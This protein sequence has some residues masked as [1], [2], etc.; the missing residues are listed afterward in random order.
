MSKQYMTQQ[1]ML[2]HL[3]VKRTAIMPLPPVLA[4]SSMQTQ[5]IRAFGI[6]AL[7]PK[8]TIAQKNSQ[9]KEM[10]QFIPRYTSELGTHVLIQRNQDVNKTLLVKGELK[11]I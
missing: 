10:P 1:D 11:S 6:P 5:C 7:W 4:P 3:R 9:E 8:S 2:V